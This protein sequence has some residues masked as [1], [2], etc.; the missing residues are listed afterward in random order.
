MVRLLKAYSAQL[1]KDTY[2]AIRNKIISGKVL[3]ADETKISLMGKEGYVWV[4]TNLEEVVYFYTETREGDILRSL[5]QDF[6]GVLISDFYAG[7]DSLNCPQQ[8][9]LIHLIRDLNEDLLRQPFNEELSELTREFAML[10]KPIIETIDR[11]G[12]KTHFLR[13]HKASVERFYKKLSKRNYESEVVVKYKKRIDKN[14]D[15]LFT[16]LDYDGI[17]WNNNNAE[18]AIKAFVK[19]RNAISGRSSHKGIRE[20]LILLSICETCKYKG[21]SFLNFLRSGEK[22]IDVFI[23]KGVR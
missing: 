2:E 20:Y 14:R 10:L 6:K 5:L 13:K 12:L 21:I 3:H 1:Y 22:D 11:F 9:C 19:F 8:K 16:F 4:F 15:K 7:Y 23:A 18:H 17:P